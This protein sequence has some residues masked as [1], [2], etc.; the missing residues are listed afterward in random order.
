MDDVDRVRAMLS[1]GPMD[2]EKALKA[3]EMLEAASGRARKV[4]GLGTG[5][6]VIFCRRAREAGHGC[7]VDLGLICGHTGHK[8]YPDNL[9]S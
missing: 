2:G 4:S 9:W 1:D 6:D 8:V 7:F 5:E 3:F